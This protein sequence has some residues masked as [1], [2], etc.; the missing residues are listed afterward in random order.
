MDRFEGEGRDLN[1]FFVF[2]LPGLVRLNGRDVTARD[3]EEA[4]L[5]FCADLDGDDAGSASSEPSGDRIVRY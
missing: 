2:L 4:R 1:C 3:Q 5:V